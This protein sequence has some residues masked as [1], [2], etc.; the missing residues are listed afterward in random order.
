MTRPRRTGPPQQPCHRRI[1]LSR[2]VD[3]VGRSIGLADRRGRSAAQRVLQGGAPRG[4]APGAERAQRRGRRTVGTGA[5]LDAFASFSMARR[6]R[7][8][9]YHRRHIGL[10]AAT[11]SGAEAGPIRWPAG[12]LRRR[13]DQA[14]F[15]CSLRAGARAGVLSFVLNGVRTEDVSGALDKE[16]IAVRSG[17]HCAQPILRRFGLEATVR[18]S[19]APY[20]TVDDIDALCAAL[21]RLQVGHV[22]PLG[23]GL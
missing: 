17:H 18:A 14:G 7:A 11:R 8:R 22:A 2:T 15:H 1:P 13:I 20:N 5:A 12:A 23:R 19:L 21:L 9:V 4:V 10:R 16:G 6:C 3:P